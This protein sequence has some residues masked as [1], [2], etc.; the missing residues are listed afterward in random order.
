LGLRAVVFDCDGVNVW[1][2]PYFGENVEEINAFDHQIHFTD[3][4][5][6]ATIS[7]YNL[8]GLLVKTLD[9]TMGQNEIWD[10]N[11][12]FGI[13]VASG[14]YIAHVDTGGCQAVLKLA[15]VNSEQRLD[16]Y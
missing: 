5:E 8:N 12:S 2:N 3:L 1:P 14:M 16:R 7:I 6:T 10:M 15:I 13:P 4:P 9:H 11:N